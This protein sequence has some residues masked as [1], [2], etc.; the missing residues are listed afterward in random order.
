MNKGWF[1]TAGRIDQ[2]C[3]C[4]SFSV[5][6]TGSV[7]SGIGADHVTESSDVIPPE[8]RKAASQMFSWH[9]VRA[10]TAGFVLIDL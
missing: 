4:L 5:D 10:D 6:V 9:R 7:W 3:S 2:I 1:P 8:I